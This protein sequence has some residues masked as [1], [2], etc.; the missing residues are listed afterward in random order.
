MPRVSRTCIRID[1]QPLETIK[2]LGEIQPEIRE[3]MAFS[4]V[5]SPSKHIS[6]DVTTV[7]VDRA[8]AFNSPAAVGNAIIGDNPSRHPIVASSDCRAG[9]VSLR[10]LGRNCPCLEAMREGM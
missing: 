2:K 9:L 5:N 7:D 3:H 1:E 10:R 8:G 6:G 4:P